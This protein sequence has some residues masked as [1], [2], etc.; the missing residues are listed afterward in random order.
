MAFAPAYGETPFPG[1][2]L[3]A[4]LMSA[5]ELLDV[6]VLRAAVYDLE[7]GVQDQVAERLF[8]L[9]INGDIVLDELLT[10]HFMRRVHL[11]LY[12][13]IW[14]WVGT[15]RTQ[16]LNIGVVPEQIAVELRGSLEN[17]RSRWHNTDDW[18]PHVLGIAVHAETVRI[19]PFT[20][21]SGRSTRLLADL[22][23]AAAQNSGAPSLFDWQ[24]DK[25]R[26]IEL[27]REYDVHRDPLDVS[28]FVGEAAFG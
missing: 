22:V 19:H 5:R 11:L 16:E 17:I 25:R 3:D 8:D 1:D 6:P 20:E 18:T 21:G 27:L 14:D 28:A 10:D 15:C 23:F 26:Y 9:V 7:Q 2:E 12:G 4:L 13:D 24:L